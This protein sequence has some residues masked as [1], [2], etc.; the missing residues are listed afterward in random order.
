M[1]S[2]HGYSQCR[3]RS[4]CQRRATSVDAYANTADQ[5]THSHSQS[6]PEQ[7]VSG[8]HVGRSV[9]LLNVGE[10]GQLGGEDDG[11]D[12]AVDGD[13]FAENDGDQV[14]RSYPRC[15]D[16]STE[17]GDAGGPDSPMS[18]SELNAVPRRDAYHAEPTTDSPMHSAM[19]KLANVYGEMVSRNCPT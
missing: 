8:E 6:S 2:G 15:L 14:L 11:H 18:V 9:Y 16:T 12:D 17:N 10:L 3:V 5:V 13:D 7:G 19:P 1:S 4:I